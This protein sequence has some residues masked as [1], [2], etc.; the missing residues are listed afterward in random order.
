VYHHAW[1]GVGINSMKLNTS[2]VSDSLFT[3]IVLSLQEFSDV[4]HKIEQI[5]VQRL[6]D[7]PVILSSYF[8]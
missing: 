7:V 4:I 6:T 5:S 2:Q 3:G 1:P 8:Q